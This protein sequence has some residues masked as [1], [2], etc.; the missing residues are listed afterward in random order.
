M[1]RFS[2][3]SDPDAIPPDPP[4]PDL[5][6]QRRRFFQRVHDEGVGIL[7]ARAANTFFD[8]LIP[9]SDC[10]VACKFTWVK[11]RGSTD[12][13]AYDCYRK[14]MGLPPA[15][16]ARRPPHVR[17]ARRAG[18]RIAPLVARRGGTEDDALSIAHLTLALTVVLLLV[19]AI[20]VVLLPRP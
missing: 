5:R 14:C 1:G 20:A 18:R 2:D 3:D 12:W 10:R 4:V 11:P 17:A 8:S 13:E 7:L 6:Q 19:I 16:R 15:R 9:D